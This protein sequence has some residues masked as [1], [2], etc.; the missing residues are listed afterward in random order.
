MPADQQKVVGLG[1]GGHAAV[2]IEL[3]RSLDGY[4]VVE[5]TDANPA[6]WGREILGVPIR[7]GD[8]RLPALA[9]AGVGGAFV[10]VGAI[11]TVTVRRKVFDRAVAAGFNPVTLI[12]P[13]A[14]VAPSARLGQG[15][16]VLAMAMVGTCTRL[17]ANVTVYSGVILEHDSEVGDHSHLS[18]GVHIAGG[19]KI[20]TGCFIGIGASIIQG[21]RIGDEAIVGAGA[22]VLHDV[23]AGQTV[24][25]VPAHIVDGLRH[26]LSGDGA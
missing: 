26:P 19:V 11:K 8:E 7:G 25:G 2:L 23:P 15:T 21:V 17:G 5:L 10:G 9:A 12:H 24:V 14:D 16:C 13:S 22:V 1:A 6:L 3:L 4:E 20:G 18:P